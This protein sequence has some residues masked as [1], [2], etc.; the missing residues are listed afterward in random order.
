MHIRRAAG[1][2]GLAGTLLVGILPA[3]AEE[4]LAQGLQNTATR[5]A[6]GTCAT[7]HGPQGQSIQPKFPVL[8]GQHANYLL[9]QLQAF[10]TQ[11]RGDPDAI[12]Y[13]WGMAGPLPDEL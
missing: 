7:C 12:G 11:T 10:K 1:L 8:A 3:R 4:P 2:L 6:V 5:I 13:M 9:A